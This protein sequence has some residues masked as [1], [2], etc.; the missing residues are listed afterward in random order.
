MGN[1]VKKTVLGTLVVA[2]GAA[3]YFATL[4]LKDKKNSSEDKDEDDKDDEIHFIKISDPDEKEEGTSEVSDEVKEVCAV[5]PYLTREFVEKTLA[6]NELLDT[7]Y[8]EDTLVTIHHQVSFSDS[9]TLEGFKQIMITG[10]YECT[11]EEGK[12]TVSRKFYTQSGALISDILNVANQAK[13]LKGS[14][15]GYGIDQ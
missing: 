6:A 8:K 9:E 11:D 14:Y 12:T 7:Q 15:E 1:F 4:Y 13:A 10:G 2:A 5:Y 3:A